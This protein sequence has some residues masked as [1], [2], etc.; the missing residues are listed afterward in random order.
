MLSLRLCVEAAERNKERFFA[1]QIGTQNNVPLSRAPLPNGALAHIVSLPSRISATGVSALTGL[2]WTLGGTRFGNS[3]SADTAFARV[4]AAP[5]PAAQAS[6]SRR[7]R[8]EIRAVDRGDS[9][10]GASRQVGLAGNI[11]RA[12]SRAPAGEVRLGP[13]SSP[14]EALAATPATPVD[15]VPWQRDVLASIEDSRAAAQRGNITDAE[16]AAD[17]AA[18]TIVVARLRTQIATPDFFAVASSALDRVLQV[19]G[20]TARLLEHVTDARIELAQLRTWQT[21]LPSGSADPAHDSALNSAEGTAS[22]AVASRDIPGRIAVDSPRALAADQTLTPKML[23]G[24]YL[25][26]TLMADSAEILLP[27]SSRLM[28][29]NVG[30]ADMTIA[31][32]AQTLDSIHWKNITFIGTRLRFEGG[33]IDLQNVHFIHCTFGFP[34]D[35][36]GA[37]LANAIALGQTTIAIE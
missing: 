4:E 25:D 17:R 11:F 16:V 31:G 29:D 3:G 15:A 18:S 7:A 8:H 33:G 24:N 1:P 22:A 6:V 9:R 5:P 35:L 14:S 20:G 28:T 13:A 34:S 10:S 21:P 12:A 26:A 30:V 2:Q 27:P 19:P 36:R 37:R 23:G 32:A